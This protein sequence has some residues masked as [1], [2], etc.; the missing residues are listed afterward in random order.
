[1]KTVLNLFTIIFLIA[2]AGCEPG[3]EGK[4]PLTG[5]RNLITVNFQEGQTLQYKFSSS[6][7]IEV[8]WGQIK[9]GSKSKPGK[10]KV[11]KSSESMDMVVAYTPVKIDPHGPTT[12]NATCNSVSVKRT[13]PGRQGT[14]RDA[15]ETLRG[16]SFTFTVEPTG[17]I[18]DYS[19]LEKLIKE[20]GERAFRPKDTDGRV[21]EPDMIADFIATQWFLWDSIS[22][23]KKPSK[24]VYAG[25]SWNSKLSVPTPMV[26]RKARDVIYTL[27]EIRQ[28]EK[29]Q[30]A[31][32]RSSYSPADSA[33]EN[34]PKPYSGRFQMSGRFGFLR[35]YRL[36]DL[37]GQGE[38]LFNI[39]T[40]Q[41]ERYNQQYQAKVEASLPID[42]GPKPLITIKQN[43]IMELL[44]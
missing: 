34:W 4:K 36:L 13:S 41:T 16:A 1:M 10:H 30:L 18:E 15:V 12:I 9:S 23:I 24:G 11:D 37:Q 19:Q 14:G 17:R 43:L 27:D 20:T 26:T 6:R 22:S 40:G 29:G 25:Q 38:E 21:K 35:G 31:V 2:L 33:P 8:D 44:K 42:I 32:I 5:K 3:A 7:D 28:T 39:D